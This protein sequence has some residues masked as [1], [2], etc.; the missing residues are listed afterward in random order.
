MAVFVLCTYV[1]CYAELQKKHELK[2][3]SLRDEQ[4]LR[5]KTEVHEIEEVRIQIIMHG[6][7]IIITV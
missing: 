1:C 7:S 3:H 2:M 4:E 5:R 6:H